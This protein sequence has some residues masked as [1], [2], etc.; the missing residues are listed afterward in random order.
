MPPYF[1]KCFFGIGNKGKKQTI[2]K[3]KDILPTII[4]YQVWS[5]DHGATFFI[6]EL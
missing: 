2:K 1:P 6:I 3:A 5:I 4:L